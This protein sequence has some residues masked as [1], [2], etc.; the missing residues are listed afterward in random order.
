MSQPKPCLSVSVQPM[1]SHE[2]LL[3][4]NTS[5]MHGVEPRFHLLISTPS[6]RE[7]QDPSGDGNNDFDNG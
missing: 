4:V 7:V 2:Q 1:V 5:P 3:L 6:P